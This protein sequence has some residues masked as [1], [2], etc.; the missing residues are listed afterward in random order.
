MQAEG[1]AGALPEEGNVRADY[2]NAVDASDG[3][4]YS[5][6]IF[7]QDSSPPLATGWDEVTGLGTFDGR[8]FGALAA[9]AP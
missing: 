9:G 3:T 2:V 6:R 8:I 1:R 4:V 5:V 7:G